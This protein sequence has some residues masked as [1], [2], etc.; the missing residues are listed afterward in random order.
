MVGLTSQGSQPYP[1]NLT[2]LTLYTIFVYQTCQDSKRV[3][4]NLEWQEV[5]E[6]E[7]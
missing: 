2:L 4:Q 6:H 1:T 5:S 7:E 3:V